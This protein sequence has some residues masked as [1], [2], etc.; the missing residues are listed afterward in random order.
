MFRK[1]MATYRKMGY[2]IELPPDSAL[3]NI[4]G[5]AKKRPDATMET[6]ESKNLGNVPASRWPNCHC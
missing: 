5:R 6:W 4:L 1:R 3:N 2:T